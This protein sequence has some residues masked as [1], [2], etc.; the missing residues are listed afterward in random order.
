MP[1]TS[2]VLPGII[3]VE[4]T[5]TF[6]C[7]QGGAPLS[8]KKESRIARSWTENAGSWANAIQNKL[9]GSRQSVT[10]A[11]IIEAIESVPGKQVLDVGCGEGWLARELDPLGYQ[12]TGIDMIPELIDTARQTSPGEYYLLGYE[13]L[14]QSN[15]NQKFDVA[16]C[17]FSLLGKESVE[18]LFQTL[19]D[20]LHV[21]GYLLVQTLHPITSGIDSYQCG[22]RET[23]FDEI[24]DNFSGSS[25]WYFR[26]LSAWQRLFRENG[27]PL[28]HLI[29]PV[30]G[31]TGQVM[32][33]IM[34]GVKAS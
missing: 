7:K 24:G 9:I 12:V 21:G 13:N 29:E 4:S 23:Q 18:A 1:C 30:H 8:D 19:S 33:L 10:N 3:L 16:V 26:T 15:L 31:S 25:P 28:N 22:W 6:T 11:A 20:Y 5:L 34:I 32:S 14:A 27:F 17:N 2:F